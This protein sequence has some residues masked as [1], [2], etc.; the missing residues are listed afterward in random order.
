V[1]A[2]FTTFA[3][4]EIG[5]AL[6]ARF[7]VSKYGTGLDKGRNT[8]G[9]ISGGQ[10][11][12][13]G[14]EYCYYAQNQAFRSELFDFSF[15]D[16][17]SYALEFAQYRMRVYFNGGPVLC[18]LLIITA[19]TNTNPLTVTVP[20]HDYLPSD[21]IYFS[22]VEGM[23]EING[24]TLSVVSVAGDVLTFAV[25]ATGWGV[26]TGSGGGIAGDALG[27]VGGYPPAPAPGD[28]DPPPPEYPPVDPDPPATGGSSFPFE[29]P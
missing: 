13:A 16:E 10:Y 3:G 6:S 11:N 18:P 19:A 12:R 20:D 29:T 14:L 28:P 1:R 2:T 27:G 23:T 5:R 7:D 4:G 8:L 24:R 21:L 17:Q 26:F 15:S 25:D 9:L 22:D